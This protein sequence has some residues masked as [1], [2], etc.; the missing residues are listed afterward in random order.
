MKKTALAAQ[1]LDRMVVKFQSHG[2][3][4]I[5]DYSRGESFTLHYLLE[6]KSEVLP[7]EISSASN[8]ST[9]R[10]AVLLGQLEQKGYITREVSKTDRRKIQVSLTDA[11]RKRAQ[12][13]KEEMH[14]YLEHIF[15]EMGE[16]DTEEF[17]RT[18]KKFFDISIRLEKEFDLCRKKEK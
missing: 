16:D 12:Q 10:I 9:A 18:A 14:A 3:E 8:S 15:T 7:S 4:K 1:A 6:K 2:L 17:L 13:E 5:I 11:G